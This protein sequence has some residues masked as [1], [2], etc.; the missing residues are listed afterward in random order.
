MWPQVTHTR[1]LVMRSSTTSSGTSRLSTTSSGRSEV[2]FSSA[3]AW[4]DGAREAV[5]DVA[6]AEGVGL[7]QPLVDHAHHD[8]VGDELAGVHD[9]L[10]PEAELG[11]PALTAARSMSPVE[12]WATA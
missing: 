9:R 2:I 7:V 12:M 10:G 1:R 5:E 11:A 6:V 4:A 8:L 3:R